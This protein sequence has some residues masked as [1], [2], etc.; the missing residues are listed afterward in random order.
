MFNQ[1]LQKLR[2]EHGYSQEQLADLLQVSRQA[3]S[4]WESGM[5][6]PETDKLIAISKLF[7]ISLDSLLK[8]EMNQEETEEVGLSQ[9]RMNEYS[10]FLKKF[11]LAITGGVVLCMLAVLF[12]YVV[13][14]LFSNDGIDAV[15]FFSFVAMAVV[16]FV[17]YGIQSQQYEKDKEL[18]LKRKLNPIEQK[19]FHHK[20]AI[21]I[22]IGV[23]FCILSLI[24]AGI[25]T[26]IFGE[27]SMISVIC[28]WIF[29][30]MGVSVFVYYGILSSVYPNT[31]NEMKHKEKEKLDSKISGVIM[32]VAT[33]IYLIIGFLWGLWHPGWIVFVV[34]GILCGISS[35]LL[36]D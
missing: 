11:A 25:C 36:E 16:L 8:D 22:T 33:M 17:Y 12:T 15:M 4:K 30:M 19:Q 24:G 18:Y 5:S 2:K 29:V 9:E 28:F 26:A 34:G 6:Y 10:K 14:E 32:L 23:V 1:K 27:D 13:D 21:A 31:N 3:V 7:S 35:I 20:F